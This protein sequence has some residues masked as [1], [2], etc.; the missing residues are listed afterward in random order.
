VPFWSTSG[1]SLYV[2]GIDSVRKLGNFTYETA[3]PDYFNVM[4]TRILRG[5]GFTPADR[6][7]APRVVVVSEGMAKV[8][9]PGKDALG[10]CIRVRADT[11]PCTTVVGIA[12]DIVQRDVTNDKRYHYY[13]PIEQDRPAAGSWLLV[14]TRADPA[15]QMEAIRKKLQTVMP[16]QSY[17]AVR[18]MREAVDQAQRSWQLGATLFV[19]FGALALVVAAV[20]LYGV[21]AYNVAQRMHELGVR[22]ALGAQT[23]DILRLVVGQGAR[24]AVAGV[25][26]GSSLAL[27]ASKWLQPL[28]FKQSA[29]DPMLYAFVGAVQLL[30]ALAATTLPAMRAAKADPNKAIRA[31]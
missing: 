7:G 10:Q 25:L 12:E 4:G 31:D 14:K 22:I 28:L 19:A 16:G 29:K 23:P 3:T 2:A 24:F 13:L 5:R 1:T 6:A 9:W 27:V 26:V 17:V 18:L 20:G 8:L 21:I 11:M 30:V 15:T